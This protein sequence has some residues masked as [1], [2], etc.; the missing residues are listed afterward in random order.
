MIREAHWEGGSTQ[1]AQRSTRPPRE[2]CWAPTKLNHQQGHTLLPG[3]VFVSKTAVRELGW[4]NWIASMT[5][6][7]PHLKQLGTARIVGFEYNTSQSRHN[8][9]ANETD[10]KRMDLG[11]AQK[12]AVIKVK[13]LDKEENEW[14]RSNMIDFP[15][16]AEVATSSFN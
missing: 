13:V 4:D 9:C 7:S 2:P 12:R 10:H 16:Q 3:G 6:E 8:Q 5:F 14:S 15:L 11:F 1:G